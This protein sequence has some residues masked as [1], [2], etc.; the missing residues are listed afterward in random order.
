MIKKIIILSII[1]IIII[2]VYMFK[3]KKIDRTQK[4]VGEFRPEMIIKFD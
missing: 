1:F 4:T 2:F 3:D